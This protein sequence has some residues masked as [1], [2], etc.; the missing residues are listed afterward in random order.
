LSFF[1]EYSG[2]A[3]DLDGFSPVG[4]IMDEE[5][6]GGMLQRLL[7]KAFKTSRAVDL[8]SL[9]VLTGQQV[10]NL[11]VD[12]HIIADDGNVADALVLGVLAALMDFRRP[13]VQVS[14]E[15]EVTV[16]SAYER[17]PVPLTLHHF[18]ISCSFAICEDSDGKQIALL[19]PCNLEALVE[20]SSLHLVMNRQS[21][22]IHSSK[23]GGAGVSFDFILEAMVPIAKDVVVR[24][25]DQISSLVSCRPDIKIEK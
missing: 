1:V 6:F 2:T 12:A 10:W 5:Q 19:D 7:E 3:I 4:T 20:S 22:I 17:H 9:C 16:F 21:E 24:L 25:S 23:P 18:P 8:E 14:A 11:R 13:D 15:G